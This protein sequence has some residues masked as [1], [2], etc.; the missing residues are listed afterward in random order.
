MKIPEEKPYGYDVTVVFS[1]G[2]TKTFHK[3]GR[4][5]AVRRWAMMKPCASKI[6]KLDPYTFEEWCRVY[7][8]PR[9]KNPFS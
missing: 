5:S 7:G 1:D 9:V 6:Y 3:V 2:T 4:E 8:D